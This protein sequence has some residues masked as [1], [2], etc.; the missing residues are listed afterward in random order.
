[1]AEYFKDFFKFDIAGEVYSSLIVILIMVILAIIIGIQ[2]ARQDPLK[3][4]KGL[5]LICEIG[6]DFFDRQVK[7]LMGPHFKGFGGFIM[8]IATYLFL[9]F[10]IGLT[11]LPSP[12]GYLA[13][14]LSLALITFTLIHFT[15]VKYTKWAYFKRY[16][17]PIPIFLPINLISMWAPLLS[18]TLRLFGNALSGWTLMTLVYFAFESLSNM[19]FGALPDGFAPLA[20][21][22]APVLHA[23]FD[24]FSGF[25][26]TTVFI[27]LT[28]I[29]VAQEGPEDISINEELKKGGNN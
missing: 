15:S 18:L 22:V 12:V 5:L 13:V 14:P 10:I 6:I 23:Y 11:G 2:A 17:D 1:M 3:K 27:F 29:F 24:I 8:G 16:I 28:M 19:I 4:S 9:S 7:E 26:Q 20:M 21:F 25:I